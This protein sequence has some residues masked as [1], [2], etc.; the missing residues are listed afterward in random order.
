MKSEVLE[1]LRRTTTSPLLNITV[2]IIFFGTGLY[3]IGLS[4]EELIEIDDIGAHHGAVLFGLFHA[5]K[6][7]PDLFEGLEYVEKGESKEETDFPSAN[8]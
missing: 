8:Q 5:L 4:F 3:E 1:F 7:L 6:Y 2:G